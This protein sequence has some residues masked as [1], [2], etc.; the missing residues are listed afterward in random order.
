MLHKQDNSDAKIAQHVGVG[1]F[2][3]EAIERGD[4]NAKKAL[5]RS[6]FKRWLDHNTEKHKRQSTYAQ[7]Y[8]LFSFSIILVLCTICAL[9]QVYSLGFPN[10]F[11][12]GVNASRIALAFLLMLALVGRR[13]VDF[14]LSSVLII[15]F[16]LAEEFFYS[17]IINV[18]YSTL[19]NEKLLISLL[20]YATSVICLIFA[21]NHKHIRASVVAFFTCLSADLYWAHQG[22]PAPFISWYLYIGCQYLLLSQCIAF[23]SARVASNEN[24]R[25]Q[26]YDRIIHIFAS[27]YQYIILLNIIEFI[28][29]HMFQ[30]EVFVIYEIYSYVYVIFVASLLLVQVHFLYY[31][32]NIKPLDIQH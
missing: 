16:M 4:V 18:Y 3:L 14:F 26:N 10:A 11:D 15:A 27:F 32:D 9:A 7:I 29:R 19:T 20:L 5:N 13:H 12:S 31:G 2:L 24:K 30:I 6:A 22:L 17:L 25:T 23:K 21:R 8:K 28:A 1:Q